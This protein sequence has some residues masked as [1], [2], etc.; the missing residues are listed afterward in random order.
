LDKFCLNK[1]DELKGDDERKLNSPGV[2]ESTDNLS[3]EVDKT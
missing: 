1:S 3:N 2:I